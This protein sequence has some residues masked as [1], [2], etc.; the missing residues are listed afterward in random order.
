[1]NSETL[2]REGMKPKRWGWAVRPLRRLLFR[3]LRPYF[4]AFLAE[5]DRLEHAVQGTNARVDSLERPPVDAGLSTRIE[6]LESSFDTLS[7]VVARPDAA[8]DSVGHELVVLKEEL[9][10]FEQRVVALEL[11]HESIDA[12][13]SSIAAL[14]W[15]RQAV[16]SRLSA[17][18]D[19][20]AARID[21]LANE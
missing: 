2:Y 11:E 9:A 3:V 17:I 15:D 1:M 6:R 4:E 8:S 12:R 5:Q 7:R 21:E 10:R 18:E 19:A 13:T 14:E 16:V 20:L